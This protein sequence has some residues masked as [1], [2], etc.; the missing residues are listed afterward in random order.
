[1]DRSLES[2]GTR[3]VGVLPMVSGTLATETPGRSREE[4]LDLLAAWS[5]ADPR[6][7]RWAEEN[8]DA[9]ALY[10]EGAERPDA[11][12]PGRARPPDR[13]SDEEMRALRSLHLL[14]LIEA[15]R[16]E[17][18]GDMAEAWGWYRTALRASYH[19]GLRGGQ[20]HRF[21]ADRWRG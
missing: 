4:K 11:L 10:R 2:T 18:R 5:K 8:R 1:L 21:I 7:R 15:S 14:A 9:L 17:V 16:L 3:F 20:I 13:R 12:E 19:F 6:V